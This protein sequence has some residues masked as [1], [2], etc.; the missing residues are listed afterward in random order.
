MKIGIVAGEL[1]GDLLGAGLIRALRQQHPDLTVTGIGGPAMIAEGCR[2]LFDLSELSVMGLVEVIK[3]YPR[4]RRCLHQVRDHFLADP[5]D[6]FIGI[7]APD[8]NLRLEQPLKQAGIPTV[9]YVSPTVWAWRQNRLRTIAKACDL[10]LTLFPFEAEYYHRHHMPVRFVGH[11]LADEVAIETDTLPARTALGL[12]PERPVIALLP[13][14]RGTEMRQLAA[15]FLAAADWLRQQRPDLQFVLPI[16]SPKLEPLLTAQLQQLGLTDRLPL[17]ILSGQARTAMAAADVILLASGTASLE[18]MLLKRPMVVAYRLNT[19]TYWLAR[20]L[21]KIPHFALP[22]LL[23]QAPLVPELL[24]DE[25]TP[26]RLGEAVL[27]WLDKPKQI[28]QLQQ[29]FLLLHYQLRQS[30]SEQAARSVL[31]LLRRQPLTA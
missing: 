10:M 14:S 5:P 6:V 21:V 18:A 4:L 13:G 15:P 29:Q 7:D 9:H 24:Q 30:A 8:F 2:S 12:D 1:S 26:E 28:E 23:A 19:I 31:E 27:T 11:P 25:V 17:T 22:N 16:A 20:R 3:H